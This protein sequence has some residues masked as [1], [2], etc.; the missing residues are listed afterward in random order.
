MTMEYHNIVV[1]G[2]N[3]RTWDL[4]VFFD[5]RSPSEKIKMSVSTCSEHMLYISY[6]NQTSPHFSY[7]NKTQLRTRGRTEEEKYLLGL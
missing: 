1:L 2:L 5:A 3:P 4:N 7:L 6:D